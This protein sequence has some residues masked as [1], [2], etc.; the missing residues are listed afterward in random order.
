MSCSREYETEDGYKVYAGNSMG[1]YGPE[2]TLPVETIQRLSGDE[3]LSVI[4]QL[5]PHAIQLHREEMEYESRL[6]PLSPQKPKT[7]RESPGYIYLVRGVGT[8]WYKIGKSKNP[9]VRSKQLGTQGPFKHELI[10]TIR[11]S[12]MKLH[13]E[14]W[15]NHFATKRVEGE[16]FTL[17]DGDV[18]E[19]CANMEQIE[20]QE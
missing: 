20:N 5:I 1:G 19:F 11:V 6:S 14:Y 9:E 16:W 18:K 12:D 4:E 8:P 7:P 15:H 10:H 2:I 3:I 17:S 13:E